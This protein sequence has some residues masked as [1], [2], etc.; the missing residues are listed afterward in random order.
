MAVLD[1]TGARL[2]RLEGLAAFE[3]AAGDLLEALTEDGR[4]KRLELRDVSGEWD[5]LDEVPP[6]ERR[7]VLRDLAAEVRAKEMLGEHWAACRTLADKLDVYEEALDALEDRMCTA[8]ELLRR[9]MMWAEA[10]RMLS[11]EA[12]AQAAQRRRTMCAE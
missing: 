7:Q 6:G 9:P 10:K 8:A 4:E 11:Q 3:R 1:M 2:E 12:H 5:S